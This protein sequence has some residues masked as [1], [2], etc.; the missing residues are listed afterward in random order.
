MLYETFQA[1]GSKK[2]WED[3][4]N[5]PN[6]AISC[7][8]VRQK[9]NKGKPTGRISITF[10]GKRPLAVDSLFAFPRILSINSRENLKQKHFHGESVNEELNIMRANLDRFIDR[11]ID[12]LTSPLPSSS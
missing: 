2:L 6:T 9:S 12:W 7:V 1:K 8:T 10:N 11:S 3:Q 4:E 5:G